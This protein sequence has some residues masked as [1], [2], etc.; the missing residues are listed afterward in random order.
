MDQKPLLEI[1]QEPT[2]VLELSRVKESQ[3]KKAVTEGP[4]LRLVPTNSS[5]T[6]TNQTS[7]MLAAEVARVVAEN[8]PAARRQQVQAQPGNCRLVLVAETRRMVAL[9]GLASSRR[10]ASM[11][12]TEGPDAMAQVAADRFFFPKPHPLQVEPCRPKR[13][14]SEVAWE[15]SA[16]ELFAIAAAPHQL[17]LVQRRPSVACV[18][19]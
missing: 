6:D 15:E 7:E 16:R 18:R 1:L 4:G 13:D 10:L 2:E 5:S 19:G 11:T 3:P 14:P 8:S 12:E 17:G 9:V